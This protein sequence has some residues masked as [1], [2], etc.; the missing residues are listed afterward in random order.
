MPRGRYVASLVW[1]SDLPAAANDNR[2]PLRLATLPSIVA[3]AAL[4]ATALWALMS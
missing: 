4:L 2:A 3:S 1:D